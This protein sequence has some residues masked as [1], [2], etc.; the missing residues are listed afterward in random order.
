MLNRDGKLHLAKN[1]YGLK[2][3]NLNLKEAINICSLMLVMKKYLGAIKL[4]QEGD[5]VLIKEAL[6]KILLNKEEQKCA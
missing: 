3:G 4:F 5:R 6:N 1:K 2:N